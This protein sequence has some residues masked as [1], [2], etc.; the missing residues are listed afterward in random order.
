ERFE[1]AA[2]ERL[3]LGSEEP[4]APQSRLALLRVVEVA[5]V[6]GLER[7]VAA[8]EGDLRG[9]ASDDRALPDLPAPGA[10]GR[11]VD[12]RRVLGPARREV[13]GGVL[14]E[15]PGLSAVG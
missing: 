14:G 1:R 6:R 8:P 13:V 9:A 4:V 3:V 7:V 10:V 15:A 12:R 2:D 5:P 11:E